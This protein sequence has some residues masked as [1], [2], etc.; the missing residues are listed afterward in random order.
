MKKAAGKARLIAELPVDEAALADNL[1][2]GHLAGAALDVFQTEPLPADSPL[3]KTK[4]LLITPHVSGIMML[5]CTR[6]RNVDLFLE[7]LRNYME[8]KPLRGLVDRKLG[9]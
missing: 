2:S 6:D 8:G 4:K 3:W 1:E 9:Y 5:P 7:D